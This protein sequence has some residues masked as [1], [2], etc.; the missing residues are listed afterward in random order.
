MFAGLFVRLQPQHKRWLG[1]M[2]AGSLLNA[3][4]EIGCLGVIA[5]FVTFVSSPQDV[6]S[7]P[8][9]KWL[10]SHVGMETSGSQPV[11]LIC[12]AVVLATMIKNI[13]TGLLRYYSVKSGG[14]IGAFFSGQTIFALLAMPYQWVT[15][16][17]VADLSVLL[18]W[19]KLASGAME[20][21][22]AVA[23]D[24]ILL[25]VLFV[26]TISF[27]PFVV[28]GVLAGL[29]LLSYLLFRGIKGFIDAASSETVF[30]NRKLARLAHKLLYG[31]RD[32]RIQGKG[33]AFAEDYFLEASAIPLF[34]ARM[35]A[36][37]QF[38]S[39]VLEVV[40]VSVLAMAV[41]VM[42]VFAGFSSTSVMGGL[43]IFAL[44]VWRGL[45]AVMRILNQMA[46]LRG[47]LPSLIKVVEFLDKYEKSVVGGV[48]GKPE[49]VPVSFSKG[50]A[51]D[52]VEFSYHGGASV[53]K[54][55][56]FEIHAGETLGI[57]GKS[58]AGKSTL[59]DL[60]MGLVVPTSGS[61]FVDGVALTDENRV[62]WSRHMGYV[63]QAPY[64]FPGT[65]AE[66]IAFI[67][68]R[69]NIDRARVMSSCEDAFVTDFLDNLPEGLDTQVGDHGVRLSGGQMQRV[70]IA[71]ALYGRPDLLMFDEA[72]SA[73]DG[74]SEEYIKRMIANYRNK[75]T[76]VI[77]AHRLTTVRDCDRVV[78]LE[79][80]FVRMIGKPDEVLP[81]YET[82]LA[83]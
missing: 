70:S 82:E 8:Y 69:E 6:L 11:A 78:W 40:G 54:D 32:I 19:A 5:A 79:D 26:V 75:L 71:R 68:T 21:A 64:V 55:I 7:S 52:E 45:P 29:G 44:A 18:S 65:L 72:T 51:L 36:L 61:I 53:L 83:S 25:L 20:G 43:T 24:I 12:V 30:R 47:A 56:T 46:V 48:A 74:K 9:F 15:R 60:L 14:L 59:A 3:F 2:L 28:L 23:S 4:A 38:P 49:D 34:R 35:R 73:L 42:S 81:R 57:V 10:S 22:I 1:Y 62:S 16:K 33:A 31:F 58:G 67:S 39:W 13:S 80:G 41:Y 50:V 66:N 37:Q 27:S 63:P 77:V 76:M 17:S